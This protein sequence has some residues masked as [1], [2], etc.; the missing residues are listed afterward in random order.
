MAQTAANLASIRKE[1]YTQ[2]VLEKMFYEEAPVLERFERTNKYTMGRE[3][4]VPVWSYFGNGTTVLGSGGGTFN[5]DDAQDV[6][7]AS[8]TLSYAWQPIGLE[9]GALNEVGGPPASVGDALTLETEGA[10]IGLR[11]Q[12]M[13]MAGGSGDGLIAGCLVSSATTTINLDP[14][15]RG[16]HAIS[17]GFLSPGN[18]IDI[19]DAPN[20]QSVAT[21]RLITDVIESDTAPQIVINGANITTAATNFVTLAHPA[22][23]P[24]EFAGLR[25]IMGSAT[26]VVGNLNPATAGQRFWQ[27]A[28]VDTTT[29]VYSLD[30]PLLLQRKVRAKTR[31]TPAWFVTGLKQA[32]N[33]YSLLQTQVHFGGDMNLTAGAD[34]KAG[35]NGLEFTADPDIPDNE[36]YLVDPAS[37]F[38]A[39]GKY[40]K[41]VWKSE[42][43]GVNKGLDS[44][45]GAS[46]FKDALAYALALAVKRRN[47]GASAQALT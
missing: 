30:L 25:S 29:T 23:A 19:G 42:V 28:F 46:G 39:V 4:R 12:V 16:S 45:I 20:G 17:A 8:Y 7:V 6:T 1:I 37:F 34:Q 2:D 22:G 21:S 32:A 44:V 38:I 33:H 13:R 31:K 43:Q 35:W 41:P 10:M 5:P 47:T 36:L 24:T 15:K 11:R 18:T 27:P 26:S 9:F 14:A 40:T 3:V